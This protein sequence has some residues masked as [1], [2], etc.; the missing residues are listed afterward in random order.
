MSRIFLTVLDAVGAG[1]LP[2]AADYGDKGANT[3]GHVIGTCHPSLENMG[4]LGLGKIPETGYPVT[5]PILGVY[6]RA[7]EQSKGKDT[8]SGHWEIAG[9][10]LKKP[11]PVFPDGFPASFI[12]AFEDAIG[13]R[14]IGNKPSSGTVILE[15]LGE[16]HMRNK[17]PIVYTSGD[18]V[19]QIACHEELFPVEQLYGFCRTAREMLQ[20]DL[21]VGRVIARPFVGS[22]GSFVRTGHRKDFSMLPCGRTLLTTVMESGLESIGIGKIE[23]IF[24]GQG[25][26]QIDHKAGNPACLDSLIG[27][28]R[29]DFDGLCFTNLV[30]TDSVYGH[31]NDPKGFAGAL[32]AIDERIPEM[33]SLLREGDLMILTADH[34]C[35]PCDISTDHTRE[36]IPILAYTP[37]LKREADLGTRRTYADIAA[38]CAEWLGMEERFGAESFAEDI[39]RACDEGGV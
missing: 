7:M 22:P 37:G 15:E 31:R 17:T 36:Y 33:I 29:Q 20:G 11:F 35:D 25:L 39:R 1:E 13:Y 4:R 3:L 34:G 8:T 24:S 5:E 12:K 21:G 38:T 23:D 30:D 2:D 16:E 19:F 10:T 28:M 18:S 6:G 27:F 14:C 26:T 9:V 32:E